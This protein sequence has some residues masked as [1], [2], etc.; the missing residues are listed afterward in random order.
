MDSILY[1]Y[2]T[3]RRL[4]LRLHSQQLP[5]KKLVTRLLFT[6]L[7]KRPIGGSYDRGH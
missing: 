6:N 5:S 4:I 7:S 1:T 3:Y 2:D